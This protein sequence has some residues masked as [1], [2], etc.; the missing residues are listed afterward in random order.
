MGDNLYYL[1]LKNIEEKIEELKSELM[2]A[3]CL[4][5]EIL[6]QIQKESGDA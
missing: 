4:R 2:R 3:S 1:L 5:A 6:A